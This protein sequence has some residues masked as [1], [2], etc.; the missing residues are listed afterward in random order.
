[1]FMLYIK[2]KNENLITISFE[3]YTL[4]TAAH[5]KRITSHRVWSLSDARNTPQ[6]EQQPG[7]V[8][9]IDSIKFVK[10]LSK[11]LSKL[12]EHLVLIY[13]QSFL[14]IIFHSKIEF[15]LKTRSI[16]WTVIFRFHISN[17]F[18]VLC[19]DILGKLLKNTKD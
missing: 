17:S 7:P 4:C 19:M 16:F 10:K 18:L 11:M 13:F 15:K 1:M 9:S 6:Q 2:S 3:L 12:S 14:T 8:G 5:R